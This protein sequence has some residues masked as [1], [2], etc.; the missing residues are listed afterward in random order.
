MALIAEYGFNEGTGTTSADSSGNGQTLDSR[1]LEFATGHTGTGWRKKSGVTGDSLGGVALATV[2][3]SGQDMT[4]MAWVSGVQSATE[5]RHVAG[6]TLQDSSQRGAIAG[7]AGYLGFRFRGSVDGVDRSV[8]FDTDDWHHVAV[9][10]SG[11]NASIYIDGELA[12]SEGNG[13]QSYDLTPANGAALQVL[14][15][16]GGTGPN[17]IVVDDFR[18][19]DTALSVTDIV[20][21]MNTPVGPGANTG[22]LAA[23]TPTVTV[24]V[25]TAA[26]TGA[27][28]LPKR[29]GAVVASTPAVTVGVPVAALTGTT[30]VPVAH[31]GVDASTP[32]VTVG[33][34]VA[35]L[36]GT[37]AVPKR[38]GAVESST[39]TVTVGVPAA[40]LTGHASVPVASGVLD[41]ATPEVVV[42]VPTGTLTGSV[43]PPAPVGGLVA[44]LPEVTVGVPVAD[45]SGSATPPHG[46]G[47]LDALTP[48]VTVGVPVADLHG[49]TTPPRVTGAVAGATPTVVV[50]VPAAALTG[51]AS[52]PRYSGVLAGSL[53]VVTVSLPVLAMRPA[54]PAWPDTLTVTAVPLAATV[55]AVVD[56]ATVVPVDDPAIVTVV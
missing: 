55:E 29:T 39:P 5:Y 28:S 43:T 33:V 32:Q 9:V 25:P 4:A 30:S 35:S 52:A 27:V 38:T 17:S 6:L 41:S 54:G 2:G 21:Y 16:F 23:S 50:G 42:E 53:P 24:G 56:E 46:G 15:E 34:P 37:T 11:D 22:T 12:L 14:G 45:L 13:A 10:K 8:E 44:D 47:G 51:A 26:L 48:E 20:T 31:G 36:T 7:G 18:M 40:D 1:D 49:T 19:F 3:V